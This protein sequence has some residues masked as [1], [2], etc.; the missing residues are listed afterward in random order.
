MPETVLP[1]AELES[2]PKIHNGQPIVIGTT[3]RV[4]D[5]VQTHYVGELTYSHLARHFN[6][7]L[8]QVHASLAYYH[9]HQRDFSE[10]LK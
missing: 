10:Y 4:I 8:G 7:H 3:V 2:N 6:L 5:V 9:L 1:I